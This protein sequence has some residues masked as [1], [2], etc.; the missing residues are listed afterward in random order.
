MKKLLFVISFFIIQSVYA[1]CYFRREVL[2]VGGLPIADQRESTTLQAD[3]TYECTYSFNVLINGVWTKAERVANHKN[4]V[5]ACLIAR[6]Q[7]QTFLLTAA[8]E[9]DVD[10]LQN[11]EMVCD[12]RKEEQK[13]YVDVG[14]QV[15]LSDLIIDPKFITDAGQIQLV[16]PREAP[17][18]QCAI[19]LENVIQGDGVAIQNKGYACQ[20]GSVWTVWKKW[21]AA[22]IDSNG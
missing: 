13:L 11:T 9:Y 19:F 4:K 2:S 8:D 15:N 16:I 3:N 17:H 20:T 10:V 18:L 1:D 22:R 6:D 21:E 7:A 12:T 14:D 5:H